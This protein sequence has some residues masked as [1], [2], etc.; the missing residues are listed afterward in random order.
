MMPGM[1]K[2]FCLFIFLCLLGYKGNAQDIHFSQF[3]ETPLLRN[4]ALAGIF[5]GDVRFQFVYRNQWQSV[6]VPY[7]TGSI[8]GEFKFPIGLSNDFVTFG[9][10]ILYDKAGTIG[11]EGVDLLPA[12]NY[13]KSLSDDRNQY[14]SFGLLA[15]INTRS[16]DR[17]KV[18]TNDQFNTFTNSFD[19]TL[20]TG[21][22]FS[23]TSYAYLD[24]NTGLSFSSEL[25][26]NPNNNMFVGIAMYHV[27]QSK[28]ISFYNN[29]NLGL[30]PR[31]VFNAGFR[32][33]TSDDDYATIQA[34][35]DQQGPHTEVIGGIIYTFKLK[36]ATDN[37]S[38]YSMDIGTLI[39]INDAIIP[40]VKLT[41]DPFSFA[42]SYDANISELTPASDGVGGFEL[43]I[44]YQT[45][46][47]NS[48]S[49]DATR[50]PRF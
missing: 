35:Y 10:E 45:F 18:T 29:P 4:P 6:T 38:S 5:S 43:G 8:N 25:G 37:T 15:G 33:S 40:V 34:D 31:Y 36:N 3:Y 42:F 32:F 47:N 17:S 23:T 41:R 7:Q 19:P 22:K 12:F 26:N 9:G 39:R 49:K 46:Y 14:L 11:V 28:A 27:N 1:H 20:P 48:P 13:H 30:F 50:C 2:L 44:V 16:F 21:E 24:I